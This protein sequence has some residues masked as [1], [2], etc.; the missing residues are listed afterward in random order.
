MG[1]VLRAESELKKKSILW[2]GVLRMRKRNATLIKIS[3]KSASQRMY[4]IFQIISRNSQKIS[5]N[6]WKDCFR[7]CCAAV[8]LGYLEP[9]LTFLAN[10]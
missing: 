9:N 7:Y 1:D 3:P 5:L 8:V 10:F 4:K 6:V 2:N